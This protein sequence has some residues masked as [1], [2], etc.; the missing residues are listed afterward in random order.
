MFNEFEAEI[1]VKAKMEE[2]EKYINRLSRSK[3]KNHILSFWIKKV[4][5]RENRNTLID[6][7]CE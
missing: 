4:L 1:M 6:C 5:Y 7:C 3:R 2:H